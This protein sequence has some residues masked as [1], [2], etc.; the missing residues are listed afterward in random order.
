M[1]RFWF[2]NSGA[3]SIIFMGSLLTVLLRV[4]LEGGGPYASISMSSPQPL[5]LWR[6]FK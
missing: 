6:A 1:P 4:S 5:V 2:I 3:Y